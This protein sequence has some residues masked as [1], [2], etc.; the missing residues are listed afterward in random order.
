M[1]LRKVKRV[2]RRPAGKKRKAADS[3]GGSDGSDGEQVQEGVVHAEDDALA[4]RLRA[5]ALRESGREHRALAARLE[6]PEATDILLLPAPRGCVTAVCMSHD[7]E[8]V[9]C[10]DKNGYVWRASVRSA[11]AEE[12]WQ[13]VGRHEGAQVLCM[14]V[15]DTSVNTGVGAAARGDR[16]SAALRHDK[17]V[18]LI[19]TG[20]SDGVIKVWQADGEHL[21]DLISHR[22]A[23]TGLAFRYGHNVLY[24]GAKDRTLKAW[25][26]EEG[27]C[28]DTLYGP[29]APITAVAAAWKEQAVITSEDNCCRLV[30]VEKGSA[31]SFAVQ[32]LPVESCCM[33]DDRTFVVGGMDGSVSV[34]SVDKKNA[35]AKAQAA[36]GV[37]FQGDGDGLE[38][39]FDR[40]ALSTVAGGR[41]IPEHSNWVCAAAA[42]PY[43]DLV[44]T[45]GIGGELK[46][47][48][49]SQEEAADDGRTFVPGS[50][51]GTRLQELAVVPARGVISALHFA[52][53]GQTLAAA[54][55]REPRL[56]RWTT[57]RGAPN[58]VMVLPLQYNAD[59]DAGQP[60][61]QVVSVAQR[62]AAVAARRRPTGGLRKRRRL[63]L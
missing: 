36:H 51:V 34:H 2:A 42:V 33:L 47:W 54:V 38:Q 63:M 57:D 10:A 4:A 48:R 11:G 8:W 59:A 56:G 15:S 40:T 27:V 55:T 28:M 17:Y 31:F 20:G 21:R 35:V 58:L 19:A 30:K 60:T 43:A 46:L 32:S 1:P 16:S 49:V 29:T 53:D 6:L 7:S 50:N 37:G 26:V 23:V 22:A 25:S 62:T 14:S 39:D 18:S 12:D 3:G 41:N 13:Q 45:G 52:R 44:A 24:S 61:P 5:D 9:W